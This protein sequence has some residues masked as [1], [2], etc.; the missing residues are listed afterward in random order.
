MLQ[1]AVG[2]VLVAGTLG[3]LPAASA[4]TA[5]TV[6]SLTF[7]NNSLS[8]YTLGYQQALQPHNVAGTFFV[9][10]GLVGSSKNMMS[11][12]Q[13][14]ALAAAGNEVGGKTVDGKVN[15]KTGTDNQAKIDEVCNDR[16]ALISHGFSPISFA[17]PSGA[18]DANAESIVKNCG[19]GNARTAGSLSP[20]GATY[21]EKLPP[22]DFFALR[23]YAP[24]GQ[25]TLA[26]LESL[27]TGAAAHGGGWDPIGFGKVCSQALDPT[28]YSTCTSS[29][30]WVE[31]A[32]L[33]SFLSWLQ[34]AGQSGGA[35]VGT[36]IQTVGAAATSADTIAPVTTISCNGTACAT[37]TYIG[38]VSV[39]LA[40]TDTGTGVA[41]THY[42]TDGS[43][44]AL[45]SP[46]YT[47][48]LSVTSSETVKYRSWDNAGNVEAT[49]T[50]VLQVQQS[51]DTTPPTTAI[52]CNGATCSST[53]Y[54]GQVT[55]ALTATDNP[56]GWGVDQT[57]YT[58]DGSTPTTAS[59]TYS[60]PF[61]LT[62]PSTVRFFSTDLAGN[63]EQ[64]QS[65]QLQVVPNK[66]VVSLTFDDQYLNQYK[67]LRPLLLSHNMNATIYV[68]TSDSSGPFACCMSY[69][70]LRTMQ[71]EGNDIGGHG[72]EHMN[73]TDPNTTYDQKV[74]DVCGGRQDLIDNGISDP[75]SFAYP[76]GSVNATAESI[77]KSCGFQT[78][79]QGGG[80][81]STTTSPS[82]PWAETMP[83]KDPYSL[84]T[85]DVDAPN[86]KTLADLESYVNAAAAHGGG[87]IPMTFHQVCD[88]AAADWSSCMS[89]FGPVQ[90]SVLASFMDWLQN[91]GQPGGAPAGAV[92]QTVR[93]AMSG[94]DN[95]PPSTTALCNG[96][97]CQGSPYGGSLRASLVASDPGGVGVRA[98]YYTTDG[99]T[100][101]ASSQV[102]SE[103]LVVQTT[104]T[105]KFFS[106]DNA[107]NSEAVQTATIQV[108]SNADPVI[109]AAGDIA[110]DPTTPAFNGGNGTNTDCRAKGTSNLLVGADAVLPIGDDQY[111]CGGYNA[112]MQSYDPTWGRY[113]SITYPVPGDK[114]YATSGGTDCPA[115]PG[116][117]YFQYFGSRAGDPSTGYYSY[118]LGSWHVIA[119]N[120][121]PC[122]DS[123]GFCT[124]GS[125]QEKWL[126][127]DL[128]ANAANSCTLAY[129]QNPRFSSAANGGHS[130]DQQIWQ[131]LYAGGT[132]VVLN[133]DSHWYERFTPMDGAGNPDP[134]LGIREIIAG[135]GGAGLDT[136]ATQLATSVVLNNTTHGVLQMTLHAGSY[137]WRFLND[138]DGT[139][140]D[141]GNANCHGAPTPT[142]TLT[143][144][145]DGSTV[146]SATPTFSGAAGTASGDSQT[147][148]VKVYAGASAT[149]TPVQTLSAS[150]VTGGWS[151]VDPAALNPG[152]YTAIASQSNSAGNTGTTAPV[153]FTV[154][155][156]GP[157]VAVTAPVDGAR[158]T[159]AT[160]QVAGTG[161]AAVDASSVRVS[162]YA[163]STAS[164]TP[165]QTATA[166]V[167]GDGTWSTNLTALGDGTY[168][169]QAA[170]TDGSGNVG[171]SAAVTFSVKTNAPAVTVTS[172]G[173]GSTVSSATPTVGGA[174]GT[175]AGDSSQ[176]TLQVYAG[177]SATGTP[178][179]TAVATVANGA[180]SVVASRLTDGVYTAQ[181]TQTDSSGNTGTSS[182]VS[183]TV[184][185]TAPVVAIAQPTDGATVK[186]A[187]PT[188]A[189]TA[190]GSS[191]V[192]AWIYA[193]TTATGSPLQTAVASVAN[194]A[195]ST[196]VS[197]ALTDGVYTTQASESDSAGNT[198]TSAPVTFTVD[199]SGPAVTVTAP[200]AGA[201]LTSATPQVA[202]T[203][204]SAVDASSVRV[205]VYA[206][207]TASGTPAQTGTATVAG[208]GT[209]STNL[210]ALGDGTY[211]L[212][213]AQTDGSG[214][215]GTSPAVTF[216]IKTSA[217]AVT[218]TSPADGSTVKTATPTV[219][220]AAGTAAGDSSQVTLQV[221]AGSTATGTPVQTAVAT[222]ANG[223]WSVVASRLTDGVYTAQATQTDSSGNTG[224]SSTATFT[225]D[226]SGPT[227]AI[228][229]PA[230][231]AS[232]NTV[233]PQVT[234]TGSPAGDAST[235]R[236]SVYAGS[237]ASGTPTQTATATVAGAGT[238]ST[239]LTAL[240]DGTYTLQAA[241]TD[242][243]G[244][245]GTSPAV[246]FIIKTSAPAV[247]LTSPS[248]GSVLGTATPTVSGAAG[249]AAADSNLVTLRLYAGSTA[250][251]TPVQTA[252]A[253]V[254]SGAWS[255]VASRLSDGV[256]TAQ[257]TQSDS[258]GNTGTTAA[259]KFTIDTTAPVVTITQPA[260]GATITTS[261]LTASGTGG[262]VTRDASQ[263]TLRVYAGSSATGTPA[264]TVTAP[265]SAGAWTKD[266]SGLADGTYTL[267]ATQTDSAGNVGTSAAVTITLGSA[268]RATGVS[269]SAVGQGAVNQPLTISGS[270][271]TSGMTVT[272]SAPGVAVNTVSVTSSTSLAV[273]V[274]V[275][276]TA[277]AGVRDVVV[278]QTGQ[279]S[280]TCVGCLTVH[281]G[282]KVNSLAPSSLGQGAQQA[283]VKV[284]GNS[285]VSGAI[286][287]VSGSGVTDTVT[288]TSATALTL[289]VSVTSGAATGARDVT[290]VQPDG[291]R[292]TCSGCLT[293]NT[294]P[295]IT[296]VAPASIA[297]GA[298]LTVTLTGTAFVKGATVSLSG[299]GLTVGKTTWV[300]STSMTAVVTATSQAA[301]GL[302]SVT[303]TNPDFGVGTLANSLTVT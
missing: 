114:E 106:V 249:T 131:D 97:P 188:L 243:S 241:Q 96:A 254:A 67:Y 26:N 13:L 261:V 63:A 50:T 159:T 195:W 290:V 215:V 62:Q 250:T 266:V 229:A 93:S 140:T 7:D 300:S 221:Y 237:T 161:S 17:Y 263:V 278:G 28:N 4:A 223:A 211:T 234:G 127:N 57:Y 258:S 99:S 9:N 160:P 252:A 35:P 245:V 164:G 189:G 228:T 1:A 205:S 29:S 34:A 233:T 242:G 232:L 55:V 248:A 98:T 43:D 201:K 113:K 81:A 100:P 11:W 299:A 12:T 24:A 217:P 275:T 75:A 109:A 180:W 60:G 41:T 246:T 58:T 148:T 294:G 110:C 289:A 16:Q 178:V 231:G 144:P 203:G 244:N 139:F 87:W 276:A 173:D 151:V 251:G 120:T 196:A 298:T 257:A 102:Y 15:L 150:V 268:F 225:V 70:Q 274:N 179:Q 33:N 143:S 142:V 187:K 259:V 271:F 175:A 177:A 291:G 19:Y 262:T 239:N 119:L 132:D 126:Q 193:G 238:W 53:P 210:T 280:A 253:T 95:T 116:A 44:P 38:T 198:G 69:A 219:S 172:P 185:T 47:K 176:V 277:T 202:G 59:L 85:I 288:A 83:P 21:A 133:G 129:F 141:S 107:G 182:P 279:R 303:V 103:P 92:V 74:A 270:G 260:N 153:T 14:S 181:A 206:G 165:V 90:D 104:T 154:D 27:V 292:V 108:G 105:L 207:S 213:A 269:P 214:N 293:V 20:T 128:A 36:M 295:T 283:V 68:I 51:A 168:T 147:V 123:P 209:W 297:R 40:P 183:F 72:R 284:N 204:S 32:D 282:P 145:A 3:V 146:K 65:Q 301:T 115:T 174:A 135:T 162:V 236:L 240:S 272:V 169:L 212:Q 5:P 287:T 52:T 163:G 220:G 197:T 255:V 91:A 22:K 37:T 42:T 8:Q 25:I 49:Q 117:G 192:T 39:A 199:T 101:T 111:N 10:S 256:Y 222:V 73:L 118:N 208:D 78:A 2:A 6:V 227:V 158:L 76:F 121:G 285:F 61:T 184:D 186:T 167:A 88:Q 247:T 82:S 156:S 235:V 281:A 18:F 122:D 200:V 54:T 137:G 45:S 286:V 265:I 157:V 134:N 218:L 79:R 71:S 170:Q 190:D 84:R 216:S 124:A 152:T 31:L 125:A 171:T 77:V 191:Q 224:T 30:G 23:A 80:L 166:T 86:A 296:K 138:T 264:K 46:T 155:T 194:G 94:S 230:N 89:T 112:F 130:Y 302:R 267:Q 273:T 149:G 136:P 226:T 64:P 56:G 66:T 48:P